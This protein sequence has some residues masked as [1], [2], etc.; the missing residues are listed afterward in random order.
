MSVGQVRI[1]VPEKAKAGEV[2]TVRVLITHPQETLAFK[3]GK[4]VARQY[5]FL[6]RVEATYNG[7]KVFEAEM[8]QAVSQNP[9]VAFPI[10]VSEPGTVKVTFFE[11]TGKTYSGEAQIRF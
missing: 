8:T 7:K 9:L 4:P 10:K 5:N 2:V 3:D 11:T 1:R 6:H